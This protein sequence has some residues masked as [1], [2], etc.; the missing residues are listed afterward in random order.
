LRSAL[1]LSTDA[2]FRMPTIWAASAHSRFAPTW[3]YEFDFAPPPLRVAG[4]GAIHGAELPHVFDAPMP[5]II[6][7][8]A[9]ASGRRLTERMQS[10]WVSF[11]SI[12]DPNPL[13]TSPIWPRYDV[14]SRLT[15]VFDRKDRVV[16][17]PHGELRRAWGDSIIAFR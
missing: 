10:R 11:A 16:S 9:E 7:F 14:E 1:Q 8:G 3:V 2:A 17:D 15:Y 6:T 13:A 12:G 5:K 4:L